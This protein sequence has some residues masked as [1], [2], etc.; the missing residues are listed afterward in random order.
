M[1]SQKSKYASNF[2]EPYQAKPAF[3]WRGIYSQK[4]ALNLRTRRRR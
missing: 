1:K 2:W 3:P 4:Y